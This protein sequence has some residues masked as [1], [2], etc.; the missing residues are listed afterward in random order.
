MSKKVSLQCLK[1][2][3]KFESVRIAKVISEIVLSTIP[4]FSLKMP[5]PKPALRH[6]VIKN[7]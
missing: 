5:H 6:H 4:S 2:Q 1:M 3:K 7:L